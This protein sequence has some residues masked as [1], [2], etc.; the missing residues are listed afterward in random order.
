MHYGQLT[1]FP[2]L[3]Y[4]ARLM[5]AIRYTQGVGIFSVGF[6]A[7]ALYCRCKVDATTGKVTGTTNRW[8]KN[9]VNYAMDMAG[10]CV[11]SE[12]VRGKHAR[13]LQN[14]PPGKI[15]HMFLQQLVEDVSEMEPLL[16]NCTLIYS[17][18]VK[19]VAGK[20]PKPK[21]SWDPAWKQIRP[22]V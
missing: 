21:D 17:W 8:F 9:K 20:P 14:S 19:T 4:A 5:E 3:I 12:L 22:A 16:N 18:H 13:F 15:E 1:A 2:F 11:N 10:F 7:E 6:R